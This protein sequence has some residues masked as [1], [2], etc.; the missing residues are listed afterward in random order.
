MS[1][2]RWT[3][4]RRDAGLRLDRF[5]AD[6]ARLGSRG[7]AATAIER[8]KVFVNGIEV[9]AGD[10]GRPLSDGDDVR[11]WMDR[12]GSSRTR[13]RAVRVGGLDVL[14]DDAAIVV[15]NKPAGLLTVPLARSDAASVQALLASAAPG[16]GRRPLAVH[17]I[18][19]DTSGLVVFAKSHAAQAALKDQFAARE[20]ERAYVAV[21]YGCPSPLSGTWR[22]HLVWDA[23]EL[24]QQVGHARQRRAVEAITHYDVRE[25]YAHAALLDVRLETGKRNQIRVQAAAHGH[26]LVGEQQ[27]A[28]ESARIAFPRQALHAARL[29]FR[30]PVDG[31]RIEFTAPLPEDLARL[32]ARLRGR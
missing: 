31:R 2:T 11:V 5:L 28:A 7:R 14:Y 16:R 17:R 8:G 25:R 23:D 29:S 30:H 27:Y 6:P 21:V 18:D 3:A 4:N 32:I 20:P 1:D 22:D 10:A 12:P 15:V 9:T 13:A 19:R 24:T 26:P